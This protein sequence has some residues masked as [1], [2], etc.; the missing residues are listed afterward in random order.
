MSS[1]VFYKSVILSLFM[2]SIIISIVVAVVVVFCKNRQIL[3]GPLS[4]LH[5]FQSWVL[6]F[7][8]E[9]DLC[10]SSSSLPFNHTLSRSLSFFSSLLSQLLFLSSTLLLCSTDLL[11]AQISNA[12]TVLSSLF[13]RVYFLTPYNTIFYRKYL[14]NLFLNFFSSVQ[15]KD[16][17][18]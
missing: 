5:S 2:F 15:R 16:C 9:N 1:R 14:I 17:S 8:L 4:S 10:M 11:H 7:L 6:F 3:Q 13:H 12:S 18:S